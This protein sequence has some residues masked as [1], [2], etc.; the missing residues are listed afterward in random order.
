MLFDLILINRFGGG[1]RKKEYT[2][3]YLFPPFGRKEEKEQGKH[4]T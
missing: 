3:L 4:P 1:K 2:Y